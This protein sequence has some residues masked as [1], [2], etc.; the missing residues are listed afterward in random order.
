[1]VVALYE[2]GPS[3][4]DASVMYAA[5]VG[6]AGLVLSL[7]AW[8]LFRGSPFGRSMLLLAAFMLMLAIYHPL[9]LLYPGH[10]PTVLLL[11]SL[12]FALAAAFG[13]LTVRQHYRLS[14]R[15]GVR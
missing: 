8:R 10:V 5:L 6:A 7:L 13:L 12:A 11:E 9:L 2:A 3:L 1:M 14:R 15:G 4:Y